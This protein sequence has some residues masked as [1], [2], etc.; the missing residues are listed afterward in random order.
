M[1]SVSIIDLILYLSVIM[2]TTQTNGKKA[3]VGRPSQG[4]QSA[5]QPKP[6]DKPKP[7]KASPLS[8]NPNE[9]NES[10]LESL[11]KAALKKRE[12]RT[13]SLNKTKG[14]AKEL[15]STGTVSSLYGVRILQD[16]LSIF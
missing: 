15:S 16:K 2:A 12:D 6:I 8:S 4:K 7:F 9:A 3:A 5:P 10:R 14:K 13:E 1:P 11:T